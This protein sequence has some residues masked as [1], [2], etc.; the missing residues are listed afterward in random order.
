MIKCK[1]NSTYNRLFAQNIKAVGNFWDW[2]KAGTLLSISS[3]YA[4]ITCFLSTEDLQWVLNNSLFVAT[5]CKG[6]ALGHKDETAGLT[7]QWLSES[8]STLCW[9]YNLWHLISVLSGK[10]GRKKMNL[11]QW[12]SAHF[13]TFVFSVPF[14]CSATN[15][16][17]PEACAGWSSACAR[18]KMVR[19]P[20]ME[21][22]HSCVFG[23]RW[24]AGQYG[25]Q[26]SEALLLTAKPFLDVMTHWY[27][28]SYSNLW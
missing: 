17:Q 15:T 3:H 14:L 4:F 27:V 21:A 10:A 2:Q 23:W 7:S 9:T 19:L 18:D 28:S 24:H 26:I 8:P 11:V 12:G 6:P 1:K 5:L 22:G 25:S 16:N 13:F 20:E